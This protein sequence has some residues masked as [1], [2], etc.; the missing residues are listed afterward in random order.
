VSGHASPSVPRV[1]FLHPSGAPDHAAALSHLAA[2]GAIELTFAEFRVL[3]A[4][5]KSIRREGPGAVLRQAGSA[6]RLARLLLRPGDET[7]VLG[8]APFDP[9]LRVLEPALRRRRVVVLNSWIGWDEAAVPHPARSGAVRAAWRRLGAR[10]RF[11]GVSPVSAEGARAVF[12][13]ATYM[14]HAVTMPARPRPPDPAPGGP[15]RLVFLGRLVPEKGILDLPG[16]LDRLG[17][18]ATLDV[19]GDGPLA[20]AIRRRAARDRRV[21]FHGRVTDPAAKTAL[22]HHA[23][24]LLLPSRRIGTWEETFGLVV[25]EA[26]AHGV[27]AVMAPLRGPCSVHRGDGARYVTVA[28]SHAPGDL[29][30][31]VRAAAAGLAEPGRRAGAAQYARDRFSTASV[32]ERWL[33]LVGS[34]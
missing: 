17:G 19:A 5:A 34:G 28:R 32:A 33:K 24:L 2:R 14:P 11:V 30:E 27:P 25:I 12:D 16:V 6:A 9:M 21:T 1:V 4:L 26:L 18:G 7:V 29:A 8:I 20:G 3:R 22:L 23:D 13:H 10:A 31:A 15:L